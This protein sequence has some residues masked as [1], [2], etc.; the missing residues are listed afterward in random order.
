MGEEPFLTSQQIHEKIQNARD[1]TRVNRHRSLQERQQLVLKVVTSVQQNK[2]DIARQVTE[3]T[4]KPITQ[5]REEID[6]AV[7]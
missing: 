5:A 6:H 7:S 3:L 2:D 4:G 1:A